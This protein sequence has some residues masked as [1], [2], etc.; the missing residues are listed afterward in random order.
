MSA[1]YI[2][3]E[4]FDIL[5]AGTKSKTFLGELFVGWFRGF[6]FFFKKTKTSKKSFSC[7]PTLLKKLSLCPCAVYFFRVYDHEMIQNAVL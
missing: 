2:Y 6:S 3:A 5:H 7:P 4:I 1:I